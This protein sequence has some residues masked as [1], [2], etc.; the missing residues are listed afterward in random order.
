MTKHI[1]HSNPLENNNLLL[2]ALKV[3]CNKI[4]K[5]SLLKM[6]L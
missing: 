3:N 1:W 5:F 2:M 4:E 6:I